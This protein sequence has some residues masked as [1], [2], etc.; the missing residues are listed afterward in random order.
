MLVQQTEDEGEASER[1]SK[2]QYI[3]SPPHLSKDQPQA[4]I[5]PSPRPSPSIPIPDSIPEG[6]GGNHR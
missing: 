4:Q 6:S 1:P 2:S 5:D 3:P